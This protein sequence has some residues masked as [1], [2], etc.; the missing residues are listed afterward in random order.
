[1]A[2]QISF[3]A[4]P[5]VATVSLD[6]TPIE[7]GV[8]TAAASLPSLVLGLHAGAIIDRR[9]RRPIMIGA[10][11]IR[12]AMLAS[13]PFAW[14]LG[15]LSIPL[16]CLIV[17]V[18]GAGSLLFDVAYQAFL[19]SVI[20]RRRLVDGNSKLELSHTASELT[21]PGVAGTLI[22]LVGAPFA[23]LFNAALYGISALLIWRIRIDEHLNILY[24]E[25]DE[26]MWSRILAGVRVVWQAGPLRAVAGARFVL[27][28]FNAVLEAVFVLYVVRVLDVG[29]ATLGVIFGV[30]GLGFLIGALLPTIANRR[31][32]IGVTTSVALGIVG[33]SDLLVPLAEGTG[34]LI[35]PL[36]IAA[37]FFFGIG[38]TL[39]NVNQV[40]IR[41]LTAPAHLQGRTSATVRFVA[42][43]AIPIGALLGGILGETIGLRETLV[44]AAAGELV[45]AAWLWF[46]PLRGIQDL[47]E[48]LAPD[49]AA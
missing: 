37:Q 26:G 28:F 3:L 49:G 17:L 23:L 25:R 14:W 19:P 41:Q 30:G 46:S 35:V 39:F 40:S 9:S 22:Q 45:A 31:L 12:F 34:W 32:G 48:D 8:L 18:S 7:M 2:A 13:I 10:D 11:L 1:L 5:L 21:G 15:F 36:L 16:L 42:M 47:A 38:L 43:S 33:V 4:I 20:D 27:N 24:G 44:L 6:A 29:P